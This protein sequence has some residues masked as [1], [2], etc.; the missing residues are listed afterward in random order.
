MKKIIQHLKN[1][2]DKDPAARTLVEVALLYPSVHA[3]F[4]Y[5]ISNFLFK[6]KF[7][8]LARFISQFS[9]FLTGIEIHPGATIGKC[10]FVDHGNG[11]S[12]WRE[13][14]K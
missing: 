5:R 6:K 12:N 10:L 8:F 7:F 4:F 14:L 13:L 1:V 3:V 11:S 9:R 2:M